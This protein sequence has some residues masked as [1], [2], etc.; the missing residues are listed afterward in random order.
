M[1]VILS[2][3]KSYFSIQ[4]YL[5]ENLIQSEQ[6]RGQIRIAMGII[7]AKRREVIPAVHD[8]IT[9]A[10][11]FRVNGRAYIFTR[12]VPGIKSNLAFQAEI[13]LPLSPTKRLTSIATH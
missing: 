1:C 6:E 4:I 7:R 12:L 13:A 2:E 3:Q 10:H 11:L 5:P 9:V 8:I